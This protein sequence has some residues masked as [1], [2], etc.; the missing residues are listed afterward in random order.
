MWK[1]VFTYNRHL[2]RCLRHRLGYHEKEDSEGQQ[3]R[4]TTGH[5]LSG[6]WWDPENHE[7]QDGKHEAG[8]H[9]VD[10]VVVDAT[11]QEQCG[12][13]VGIADAIIVWQVEGCL[14]PCDLGVFNLPLAILCEVVQRDLGCGVGEVHALAVVGPGAHDDG[15]FL[16]VEGE[17]GDV[18]VTRGGKDATGLPV[19]FAI[20][21]DVN[22]HP[23]KVVS[24]V[25]CSERSNTHSCL[26]RHTLFRPMSTMCKWH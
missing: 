14:A 20:M 3:D 16:L 22:S 23:V 15:T 2:K 12:L 6:L 7:H 21:L 26:Y 19:H 13:N 25:L 24:H 5:F 10:K 8:Y 1:I 9:H 4:D 17:V 18:D 11:L